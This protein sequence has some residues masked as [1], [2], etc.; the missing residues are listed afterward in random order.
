[1]SDLKGIYNNIKVFITGHTGFKGSWLALWMQELGAEVAGYA[2]VPETE[3]SHFNLLGLDMDS[4]TGG[5]RDRKK[6]D[7]AL[8]RFQPE[9]V[10][11]LAAQPLVRRS[12]REPVETFETNIMGTVNLLK[13]AAIS[14]R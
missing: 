12:Y 2:L 5:I 3:P 9:I 8:Q 11:H 10:F 6:L 13:R 14:L 4:T 1:M 7:L